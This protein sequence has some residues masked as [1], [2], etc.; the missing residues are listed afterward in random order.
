[1][2]TKISHALEVSYLCSKKI[3]V[4][5]EKTTVKKQ[6]VKVT[7]LLADLNNTSDVK[8]TKA[9]DALEVCGDETI[10]EP[11]IALLDESDETRSK[12]ILEFLS[13]LKS[14]KS[15]SEIMRCL[16][17]PAF[18]SKQQVILSTIWNNPLDF[19]EYI[20]DFVRF[21]VQK[22]FLISLE[23]LTIIENL[24]GPYEEKDI[25]ESQLI[26]KDYLEGK[27]EKSPQ[28]DE[29]ISEIALIIKN[30]NRDLQD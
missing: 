18:E 12:Q 5:E 27:F 9:L 24:D 13:S 23:A 17:L 25:L 1:M 26:L 6:K 14:T 20:A 3:S 28:K 10:I 30:I 15:T 4:S 21:A 2:P 11:L 8:F 19:S 22:D 29:L 7:Q 16:H